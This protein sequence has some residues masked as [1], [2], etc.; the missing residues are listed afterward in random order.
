MIS[1]QGRLF[2]VL[3]TRGVILTRLGRFE[4]AIEDLKDSAADQTSSVV[5]YHLA[6][7]YQKANHDQEFRRYRDEARRAGISP[8]EVDQTERD[9]LASLLSL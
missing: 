8:K 7:A 4:K 1:Q 3:D 2:W 6:R 5:L 9:E